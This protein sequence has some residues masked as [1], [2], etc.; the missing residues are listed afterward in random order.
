MNLK[1]AS[2]QQLLAE[3]VRLAN[4]LR[5]ADQRLRSTVF[6]NAAGGGAT[7]RSRGSHRTPQREADQL[8]E[9]LARVEAE[10]AQRDS[11]AAIPAGEPESAPTSPASAE[12][13][14]PAP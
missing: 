5:K 8:R 3:R 12:E 9:Q 11:S 14:A 4:A 6:P 1:T 2:R 7:G 13:E 10:L